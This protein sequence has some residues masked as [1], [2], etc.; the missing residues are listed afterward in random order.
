MLVFDRKMDTQFLRATLHIEMLD[1][2][3]STEDE[4]PRFYLD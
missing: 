2:Y 4:I 3:A 1:R